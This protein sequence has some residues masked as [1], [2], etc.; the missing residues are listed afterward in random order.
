MLKHFFFGFFFL[1]LILP[2]FCLEKAPEFGKPVIVALNSTLEII[3][4]DES[5]VFARET[6]NIFYVHGKSNKTNISYKLPT[7]TDMVRLYANR[8][9]KQK[10]DYEMRNSEITF[11]LENF[12]MGEFRTITLE[13]VY[14]INPERKDVLFLF[15]PVGKYNS[16]RILIPPL[17]LARFSLVTFIQLP[18]NNQPR[19]KNGNPIQIGETWYLHYKITKISKNSFEY[20]FVDYGNFNLI[21]KKK[22]EIYLY[23]MAFSVLFIIY[24]I[25]YFYKREGLDIAILQ[26]KNKAIKSKID[27]LEEE[28]KSNKIS[29]EI[30]EKRRKDIEKELKNIEKK[31]RRKR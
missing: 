10:I 29:E 16:G 28:F 20:L 2:I 19:V 17:N 25:F 3:F 31:M 30:Y 27:R 12:V 21:E 18:P 24:L 23:L 9:V 6:D 7:K 4:M 26:A 15:F 13:Y 22:R 5:T 14:K 11:S 8:D 1:S